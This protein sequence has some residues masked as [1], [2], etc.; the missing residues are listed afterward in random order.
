MATKSTQKLNV[1]FLSLTILALIIS[2]YALFR[3]YNAGTSKWYFLLQVA[4]WLALAIYTIFF[5]RRYLRDS[6]TAK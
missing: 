6:Q 4:G 2:P 5:V 3:S 1:F